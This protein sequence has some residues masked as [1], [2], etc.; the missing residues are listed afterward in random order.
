[1]VREKP[2]V[3]IDRSD[4]GEES[5]M[6]GVLVIEGEGR[7]ELA[8]LSGEVDT[9]TATGTGEIGGNSSVNDDFS[10]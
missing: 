8:G 1:M 7:E 2:L 4:D 5:G 6:K 10:T 3:S 9:E